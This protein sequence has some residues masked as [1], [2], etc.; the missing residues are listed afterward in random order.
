MYRELEEEVGLAW[1]HVQIM[2]CT[3]DWLRYR[4]PKRFIRR[5][6]KPV[7]VGQKQKWFL[8]R[9]T[10]DEGTVRLD[11]SHRPEFDRWRWV[12]YWLPV[13]EVVPFKRGV[14]SKALNELG[15]VLFPDG[16]PPMAQCPGDW[17]DGGANADRRR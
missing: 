14:Y 8:L 10:T 17:C 12:D 3:R 1:H 9:L 5:N 15:R 16:A 6:C 2:A 11:M 13:T 4:L 7:C